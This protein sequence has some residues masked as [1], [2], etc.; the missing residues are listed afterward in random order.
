MEILDAGRGIHQQQSL[1]IRTA[2]TGLTLCVFP[3]CL[4]GVRIWLP[5]PN[6]SERSSMEACESRGSTSSL[7]GP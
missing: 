2:A 6:T 1:E 4:R 3:L 7:R 5:G